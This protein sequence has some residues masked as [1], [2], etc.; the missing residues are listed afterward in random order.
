MMPQFANRNTYRINIEHIAV[1]LTIF[2]LGLAKKVLIAD[3][4]A[5]YANP[6]FNAVRDGSM[7]IMSEAWVGA[8]T[9]TLQLYFDFSGYSDMAIGLSLMFN[10]RLPLNFYSPYKATNIIDFW[11]RWHITLSTFLRDYLY[12]PLGGNRKG[13]LRRYI[14]LMLTMLLGGLWHGA[15]WTFIIWGGLHGLYL[16][17]NHSWREIKARL[18]WEKFSERQGAKLTGGLL[19]F[20]AV[21]VAWVF[22]RAD[23]FTTAWSMLQSMIGMNGIALNFNG[24]FPASEVGIRSA[25]AIITLGLILVWFFPNVHQML[26]RYK[27]SWEDLADVKINFI[28]LSQG[29]I[30]S[31]L[32]W[33]PTPI[34]GCVMGSIFMIC[35]FTLTRVSEFLYFQF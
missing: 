18:N 24:S 32:T 11:R 20:L 16:L 31:W 34:Y 33:Q 7:L 35:V 23:S 14:N 26:V 12:I 6:I 28:S 29:S 17:I 25:I 1:G 9:Y 10:V 4:F 19:T 21:V 27:P 5:E 30:P 2:I 22:F 8:L 3:N 13:T 15:G